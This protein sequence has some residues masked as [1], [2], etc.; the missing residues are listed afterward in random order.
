MLAHGS[1]FAHPSKPFAALGL[2][3]WRPCGT[4]LFVFEVSLASISFSHALH[5]NKEPISFQ[6][7]N[8]KSCTSPRKSILQICVNKCPAHSS[9]RAKRGTTS[10]IHIYM[11]IYVQEFD[12]QIWVTI[13]SG[14]WSWLWVCKVVLTGLAGG[15]QPPAPHRKF[16]RGSASQALR[17]FGAHDRF[18]ID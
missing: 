15:M 9:C 6:F 1:L 8:S 10:S 11:Y 2:H 5:S 7:D 18:T 4:Y 17:F 3:F 13:F 12:L 16:L 14:I